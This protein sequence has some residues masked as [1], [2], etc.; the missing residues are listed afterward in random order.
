MD[1]IT[2]KYVIEGVKDKRSSLESIQ[3]T[4]FASK[5]SG[6]LPAVL[7]YDADNVWVVYEHRLKKHVMK[8]VLR[9]FGFLMVKLN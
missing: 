9:L 8:L 6:K 4:V 2:G 3:Q 5:I 7:I 1:I